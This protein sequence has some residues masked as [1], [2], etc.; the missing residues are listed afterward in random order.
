MI[1]CKTDPLATC[2]SIYKS[3][4][5]RIGYHYG[6]TFEELAHFYQLYRSLMSHWH[7]VF[8]DTIY[9]ISYEALIAAQEKET[10]S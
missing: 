4:F 6:Q 1:H 10:R 8:P 7:K 5:S 2:W 9:G 3:N